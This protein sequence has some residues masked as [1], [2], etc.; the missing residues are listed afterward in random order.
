MLNWS[1]HH[2]IAAAHES[3]LYN[4]MASVGLILTLHRQITKFKH[5]WIG[6][7]HDR[8]ESLIIRVTDMEDG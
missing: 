5:L 7:N 4:E 3:H 8:K 6:K 2:Y 1:V